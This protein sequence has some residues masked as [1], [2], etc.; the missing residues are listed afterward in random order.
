MIQTPFQMSERV[1][2]E[3]NTNTYSFV[4]S[5]DIILFDNC[6]VRRNNIKDLFPLHV[7][8]DNTKNVVIE[9]N[10][11]IQTKLNLS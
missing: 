5:V 2:I 9:N 3:N 10:V 8:V 7:Y 4:E 1:L 6:T 11:L